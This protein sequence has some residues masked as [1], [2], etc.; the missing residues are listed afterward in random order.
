MSEIRNYA[1]KYTCT[2]LHVNREV[3]CYEYIHV[4]SGMTS[5]IHVVKTIVIN[6]FCKTSKLNSVGKTG[7]IWSEHIIII[8]VI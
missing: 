2:Y 6:M 7:Q 8:S 5:L 4:V 3:S 1:L